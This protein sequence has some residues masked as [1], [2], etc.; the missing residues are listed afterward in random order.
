MKPPP[1]AYARPGSLDEATRELQSDDGAMVLA[2][3]QSLVPMLNLRVARPTTV[4][5]I[6]QL[7]GL[8]GIEMT[9]ES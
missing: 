8:Q 1:F 2:G 7:P 3:G 5:D 9:P 6:S 4:V